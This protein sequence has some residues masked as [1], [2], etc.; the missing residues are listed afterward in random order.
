MK[1]Q[2]LFF[3]LVEEGRGC[4]GRGGGRR[5]KGKNITNLSSA[6]SVHRVVKC[7]FLLVIKLVLQ[8]N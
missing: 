4:G 2:S 6:E 8:C 7:Q 3:S 5:G 1:C